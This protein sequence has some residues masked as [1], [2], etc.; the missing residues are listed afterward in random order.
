MEGRQHHE[1]PFPL[2]GSSGCDAPLGSGF[3]TGPRGRGTPRN[4]FGHHRRP[5]RQHRGHGRRRGRQSGHRPDPG[6]L[7][8]LRRRR[9]G[10]RQQLPRRRRRRTPRSRYRGGHRAPGRRATDERSGRHQP[11]AERRR[12]VRGVAGGQ[13]QHLAQPPQKRLHPAARGSGEPHGAR[14]PGDGGPSRTRRARG[15]GVHP[16]PRPGRSGAGPSGDHGPRSRHAPGNGASS[17]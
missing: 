5:T 7:P 13:R 12:Q 15:A 9:A 16:E 1:D 17:R 8:S 11:T 4:L 10:D 14:R 3:P 6:G 2:L